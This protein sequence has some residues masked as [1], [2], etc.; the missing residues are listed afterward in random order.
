MSER[1]SD[2]IDA[3]T[4]DQWSE[5]RAAPQFADRVMVSLPRG[6]STRP[7]RWKTALVS[8]AAGAAAASIA[9][10]YVLPSS[11]P[12]RA[13]PA[14]HAPATASGELGGASRAPTQLG[15]HVVA[16]PETNAELSW[17]TGHARTEV[18][19]RTGHV[20]YQAAAEGAVLIHTPT[21]ELELVGATLSVGVRG[22]LTDVAVYAGRVIVVGDDG[23]AVVEAGRQRRITTRGIGPD[24]AA[25][26]LAQPPRPLPRRPAIASQ[27]ETGDARCADEPPAYRPGE[28]ALADWARECRLR[29]DVAPLGYD[30]GMLEWFLDEIGAVEDERPR[31]AGAI[32]QIDAEADAA[33]KRLFIDVSGDETLASSSSVDWMFDEVL[34]SAADDEPA[35]VRRR[36]ARE[37]AGLQPAPTDLRH[38]TPY[39]ELVRILMRSSDQLQRAIARELGEA[40][41]DELR[42][43][44]GGWPGLRWDVAGCPPDR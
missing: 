25:A 7:R 4:L 44:W 13:R 3:A 14:P 5:H 24:R 19:Q 1:D 12:G 35:R 31:I 21:A 8:F 30:A 28:Q 29:F 26:W 2:A 27:P 16:V 22:D 10:V 33:I 9:A 41:G 43:R 40:R 38:V 18:S 36:L 15:E 11:G 6:T 37:R 20:F 23:R 17:S 42:R 34:R 32:G 39:E